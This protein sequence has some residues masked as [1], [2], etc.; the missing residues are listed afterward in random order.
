MEKLQFGSIAGIDEAGRG[1][2]AGPVVIAC[3][4]L[5]Y[6]AQIPGINDSKLL[7]AHAREIIYEHLIDTALSYNIICIDASTIDQ[8]NI[9]QASIRGFQEASRLH[10]TAVDHF[11]IDGRDLPLDLADKARAVIKGDQIHACIAAASILAKVHRDRLMQDY[12]RLYPH[13]GFAQ[14][15][16]YGTIAHYAALRKYGA[17][18]LHRKSFRLS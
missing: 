6:T 10:N 11:L 5:D 2:L 18:P 12:D 1:C 8:V 13:Y 9:R 4:S 7:S 16:G 14:H 17:C 15:K 3:V